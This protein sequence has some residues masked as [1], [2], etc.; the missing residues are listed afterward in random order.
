[1]L[2]TCP[3]SNLFDELTLMRG[4][5]VVGTWAAAARGKKQ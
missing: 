5:E 1:M 4:D 2:K 3:R